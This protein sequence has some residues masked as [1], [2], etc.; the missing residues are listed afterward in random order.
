M[1][2]AELS[3]HARQYTGE[4]RRGG[5]AK[6]KRSHLSCGG[7]SRLELRGLRHVQ[8]RPRV[9]LKFLARLCQEDVVLVALEQP[10][11]HLLFERLDL[12]AQ[13]RLRHVQLGGGF[14][15]AELISHG[16]EE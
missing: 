11:T 6:I 16:D 13:G 14:A 7:A 1:L 3:D 5:I 2:S 12:N 9:L 8:E 10:R 15:E 4:Y